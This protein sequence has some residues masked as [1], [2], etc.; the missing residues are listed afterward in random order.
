[1]AVQASRC[2]RTVRAARRAVCRQRSPPAGDGAEEST[3]PY[4]GPR[5]AGRALNCS[6]KTESPTTMKWNPARWG[7]L[8]FESVGECGLDY[9]QPVRAG[10]AHPSDYL[11]DCNAALYQ[12]GRS[13]VGPRP[14]QSCRSTAKTPTVRRRHAMST[15]KSIR[16]EREKRTHG[17]IPGA[18]QITATQSLAPLTRLAT[19]HEVD[20]IVR[21]APETVF[22]PTATSCTS[23][24]ST[25][26]QLERTWQTSNARPGGMDD[27]HVAL[28]RRGGSLAQRA[29]R[30]GDRQRGKSGWRLRVPGTSSF[31]TIAK[32]Q[33]VTL[34]SG[35]GSDLLQG[36]RRNAQRRRQVHPQGAIVYDSPP[37]MGRYRYIAARSR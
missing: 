18:P 28:D 2:V 21:C 19:I 13:A 34:P 5:I 6:R 11:F 15:M 3:D 26:V 10:L 22:P 24:V 23:F 35:A 16:I 1:M 12:S 25:G 32:G 17:P 29:L 4:K 14:A 31:S 36:G 20:P 27:R 7:Y 8:D 30:P 37:N 9:S 33:T